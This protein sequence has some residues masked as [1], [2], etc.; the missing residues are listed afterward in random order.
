MSFRAFAILLF[1]LPFLAYSDVKRPC[2]ILLSSRNALTKE[3]VI[4]KL[5]R[6]GKVFENKALYD[7][8]DAKPKTTKKLIARWYP[9]ESEELIKQLSDEIGDKYLSALVN[10]RIA[11]HLDNFISFAKNN[12][13]KTPD[14]S[15][16]ELRMAYAESLGYRI[17][18]RGVG[19]YSD[20]AANLIQNKTG[21]VSSGMRA[22]GVEAYVRDLLDAKQATSF[23]KQIDG[24]RSP[25]LGPPDPAYMLSVSDSPKLAGAIGRDYSRFNNNFGYVF[26]LKIPEIDLLDQTNLFANPRLRRGYVF[27]F[28]DGTKLNFSDPGVERLLYYQRITPDE[29]LGWKKDG[30][31]KYNIKVPKR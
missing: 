11:N 29:I 22:Y 17:V 31:S 25:F 28:E 5:T 9:D 18:Y 6:S 20:E 30:E 15:A 16:Y 14:K 13:A 7:Y 12:L 23:Y 26:K 2:E 19:L 10:P 4:T 8:L 3:E 24:K 27:I 21:L 1:L